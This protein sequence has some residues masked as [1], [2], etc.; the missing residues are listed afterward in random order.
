MKK[1]TRSRAVNSDS[2]FGPPPVL[3]GEDAV[4][5]DEL[6]GR[7][8]AAIKPVDVIEEMLIADVVASEWE[9]LRWSRLKLS[10]IQACAA[11]ALEAFLSHNLDYDLYQEHFAEYLAEILHDNLPEDDELEDR[12]QKLANDCA[13]GETE[14][15]N[16]VEKILSSIN[17]DMDG[18]LRV[19]RGHK[20]GRV[21]PRICA[22][23]I[24]RCRIS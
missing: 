13:M 1:K 12:T 5:Y 2:L 15:V 19:A 17:L 16:K 20:G 24:R 4:A 7:A 9:F 8:Y 11:K 23:R 21:N 3:P 6:L 10:L 22:P 14:A 18:V